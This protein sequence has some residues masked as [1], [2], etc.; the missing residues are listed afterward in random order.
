M[1]VPIVESGSGDI[2]TKQFISLLVPNQRHI[3]AYILYLV[4]HQ[5]DADD[6]LQDTLAEMWNK[7]DDFRE[8]TNFIAW[9][10]TIAR[11]KILSF[12]QKNKNS[13]ILFSDSINELVDSECRNNID[14]VK[15]EIDI[16][17]KCMEKLPCRHKKYLLMRYEQSL[18][19]RAIAA[20]LGI[21]M[22]AV[23]KS[24]CRIHTQLAHCV[25]LSLSSGAG[26]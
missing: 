15:F 2:R 9:G 19:F 4:P 23:Y 11:F 18:T 12:R 6:I 8:G 25:K 17:K 10:I 7:F 14:S 3:H 1:K 26:Q 13:K 21:T 20:R 24:F 5:S 16:L 22:Q